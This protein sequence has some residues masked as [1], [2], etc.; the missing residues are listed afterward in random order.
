MSNK[1]DYGAKDISVLEGLDPVKHRPGMYTDTKNP[2]HLV[3]EIL[4]NSLD[5]FS[6]GHAKTIEVKYRRD[7]KIEVSDD[8]RGIPVDI[9]PEKGI[10]AIELVFTKLHAGGK[11]DDSNYKMAGGLHG[12]GVSVVN[13]LTDELVVEV[14]RDGKIHSITFENGHVTKEL[15]IIGKCEKEDTGTKVIMTP[16]PKYFDDPDFDYKSFR[17]LLKEKAVITSGAHI[18]FIKENEDGTET[19]DEWYYE[20]GLQDFLKDYM[21]NAETVIP[22]YSDSNFIE[23]GHD[24]YEEGEGAE[25]SVAWTSDKNYKRSY[26]NLIPTPS[27]GTH[28]LGLRNGL[29]EAI[30][31]YATMH[32][33][34]PK[35]VTI[36]SD[37]I[38][39]R[40]SYVISA[41]I[42]EPQFHGQTKDK[43]NNRKAINLISNLVKY[44]FEKWMHENMDDANNLVNMVLENARSRQK[45]NQKI[46]RKQVGSIT[47]IPDKLTDCN[48]NNPE[49]TELFIVEGD[50]A[51]GSAKQGRDKETQAIMTLKG[52]P[53]NTWEV[54]SEKLFL[55]EVI[56]DLSIAIGIEPHSRNDEIDWSRLR[57]QTIAILSDADK[58]GF[59]IQVLLIALFLKHYPQ[60]IEKGYIKVVQPPLY[61]IDAVFKNKRKKEDREK[62]YYVLD[63]D[64]KKQ[65]LKK[66]SKEIDIDKD[67]KVM[68]FK[69]LGEMNPSQLKETSLSKESRRIETL[70]IEEW[71]DTI[72]EI[73]KLMGKKRVDDRKKWISDDA[74]FDKDLD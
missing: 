66:L 53:L 25:Y 57:Y 20:N 70:V 24:T 67:V 35:N 60:L 50:S 56:N 52:K 2:N 72:E 3:E 59:H 33:L 18:I 68:R 49:I 42:S 55:S 44:K 45:R 5:E 4:D 32:T 17:E 41:K 36:S 31:S 63:E 26:V 58:D 62:K 21:K 12:V 14:K 65:V 40:I 46:E 61:R 6:N 29:Y 71:E 54:A 16:N 11:F 48:S 43:L 23:K 30:K 13:A 15:K 19:K 39:N 47:K 8:G 69:G 73:D 10:S 7:K 38:W 64:E 1:K 34:I 22:V 74:V 51:G 37:D 28:V 27:D 9:H